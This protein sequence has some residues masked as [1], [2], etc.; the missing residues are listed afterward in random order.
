MWF[1]VRC[2]EDEGQQKDAW[3]SGTEK[4]LMG[5]KDRAQESAKNFNHTKGLLG[6]YHLRSITVEFLREM[7][8]EESKNSISTTDP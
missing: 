7:F 2:S 3:L 4:A 5:E 8:K 6:C 1:S